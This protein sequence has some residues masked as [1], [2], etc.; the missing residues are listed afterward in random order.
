VSV[1]KAVAFPLRVDT[2][3]AIGI[4]TT[5]LRTTQVNACMHGDAHHASGM[6]SK[7]HHLKYHYCNQQ[8][9][10]TVRNNVGG[11]PA[12]FPNNTNDTT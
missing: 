11:T 6:V 3:N 9:C 4:D 1:V 2:D 10:A 12:S 7:Y 5:V 8:T